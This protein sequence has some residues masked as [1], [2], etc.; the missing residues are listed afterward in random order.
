MIEETVAGRRG[1]GEDHIVGGG[2]LIYGEAGIETVVVI[3]VGGV[4]VRV[5]GLIEVGL[6]IDGGFSKY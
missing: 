3:V 5:V 4:A 6:R 2:V 1:G